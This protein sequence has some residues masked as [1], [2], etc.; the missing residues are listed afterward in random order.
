MS[1]DYY[2]TFLRIK[3]ENGT[4]VKSGNIGDLGEYSAVTY[5]AKNAGTYQ[6]QATQIYKKPYTQNLYDQSYDLRLASDKGFCEPEVTSID[7]NKVMHMSWPA[8]DG[9]G[10]YRVRKYT[11]KDLTELEFEKTVND[12]EFADSSYDDTKANYYTVTSFIQTKAGDFANGETPVVVKL[13][14]PMTVKGKT[15]TIKRSKL[16]RRSVTLSRTRVLA[17]QGAQGTRTYTKVSGNKRITI[18]KTTGKIK[19]KKGLKKGKHKVRVN[20]TAEGNDDYKP[21][22]IT[23]TFT[24]RVK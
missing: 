14:N 9:A 19:V 13:E 16:K 24:I 23:V 21:I 1:C 4:I 12:P 8:V 18:Y 7:E 10:Y 22:S 20:V 2:S 15:Y 5:T 3:S 6:L 17:I 11:D